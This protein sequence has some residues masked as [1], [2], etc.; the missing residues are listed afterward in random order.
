MRVAA[1]FEHFEDALAAHRLLIDENLDAQDI[2]IRSPY[3]LPEAPIP[4]HRE[5]PYNMRFIVR[6]MWAC[7]VICGW[8]FLAYT[9]LDWNLRTD[10]HP[11][12]S[13]PTN[14]LIMYEIGMITGILTTTFLFL[15]ETRMFRKLVPPLEEDLPVANGYCVLVIDGRSA[16][17]A[18]T[19]LQNR[20]ARSV[21]TYGLV[22]LLG[23][24]ATGCAGNGMIIP[25]GTWPYNMREQVVN[26]PG[27]GIPPW[28]DLNAPVG[29]V[30]APDTSLVM[31]A[32]A[33]AAPAPFE[34]LTPG[35]PNNTIADALKGLRELDPAAPDYQQKLNDF[36]TQMPAW[37][38]IKALV[39]SSNDIGK[40]AFLTQG[41]DPNDTVDQAYRKG[42]DSLLKTQTFPETQAPGAVDRGKVLFENNCAFCH[43]SNG[44]G[45]GPVGEVTAVPPPH[46][47]DG[48]IYHQ[49]QYT[50]GYFYLYIMVGKNNMPPFVDKLSPQE[51]HDIIGYLRQLQGPR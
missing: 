36:R 31:H 22:I 7:A 45:G 10:G 1:E 29:E 25:P 27:E 37:L 30:A 35:N 40:P 3:P 12:V 33:E 13:V 39:M 8:S 44:K 4:P 26:K 9:Q 17:R 11:I 16:D 6:V 51:I 19:L 23:L 43:G 2:E 42:L 32:H 24:M 48:N 14:C 21:V 47:G 49:P 18:H 41:K 28:T 5:A 50:D 15:W 38:Q 20:G 34:H 46:I